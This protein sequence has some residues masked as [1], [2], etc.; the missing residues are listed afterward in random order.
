MNSIRFLEEAYEALSNLEAEKS[1]Q[2]SLQTD[3]KKAEKKLE[4]TK[5]S[6][7]EEISET[8]KKKYA[9]ISAQ[10][11]KQISD[12]QT[13]LKQLR[14]QKDS[15]KRLK[16]EDR[17]QEKTAPLLSK[18]AQLK[19]S[20]KQLFDNNQVPHICRNRLFYLLFMPNHIGAWFLDLLIITIC[21]FLIPLGIAYVIPKKGIFISAIISF[22]CVII[23]GGL[24]LLLDH[25][26]KELHLE[27]LKEGKKILNSLRSNRKKIKK[28]IR[29]IQKDDDE[30]QDKEIKQHNYEIAKKEAQ[31]DKITSDKK[32]ALDTFQAATKKV[33]QNEI[34]SRY[35]GTLTEQQNTVNTFSE[36]LNESQMEETELRRI[37]SEKYEPYIDS[38]FLSVEK[39]NI[40]LS[41]IKNGEGS[42]ISEAITIYRN[43]KKH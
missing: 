25:T 41:M 7:N 19:S 5:K 17:I 39:V 38:D 6:M 27:S 42:N 32:D 8:I 13:T 34:E 40:L 2:Q 37:I 14:Q 35:E 43:Q 29:S 18:E 22:V 21:F 33:I 11:D 15:T 4:T 23:F 9:N 3:L 12:L 24:Y 20:L 26:L 10:Y 31:L 30:E 36:Q 28:L 16:K 1:Y